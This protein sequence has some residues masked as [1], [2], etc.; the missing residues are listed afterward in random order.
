MNELMECRSSDVIAAEINGIKKQVEKTVRGVMLTGAME[1]G[2]LLLEAKAV[3]A[4]GEWG[5][6]LMEN[7]EY[8]QT[9]ANDMMRLYTEY[10][11]KQMPLE[12]GPTNEELFGALAPSKAL[13]LLALPEQERREFVQQ[14][15]VE[16][17]S[18]KK[19]KEQIAQINAEKEAAEASAAAAQAAREAAEALTEK[20]TERLEAQAL[21]AEK[22]R[23]E[24]EAKLAN[25]EKRRDEAVKVGVAAEREKLQKELT[26]TRENLEKA[27]QREKEQEK[28]IDLLKAEKE[29]RE[30]TEEPEGDSEEVTALKEQI[31]KLEKKLKT[32]NPVM[33]KFSALLD[34]Y[35]AMFWDLADL[36]KDA[37]DP[38][39]RAKMLEVMR[40]VNSEQE[41]ELEE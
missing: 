30:E 35:Q 19:L 24:A 21:E 32:A 34:Q 20:E 5:T 31:E 37:D 38:S 9:T 2:R 14:N 18:V 3:V 11:D 10:Q 28:Q 22:K 25:A 7:V 16:D 26:R 13:A 40:R 33:A 6:W 4:H 12:G 29:E 27:L 36:A 1:I 23:L 15:P 41:K 17:I 39:D 8:S